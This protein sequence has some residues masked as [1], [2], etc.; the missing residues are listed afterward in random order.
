[1]YSAP[2]ARPPI[3]RRP[4][5]LPLAPEHGPGVAAHARV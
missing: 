1:A 2:H 5:L 4:G 3:L